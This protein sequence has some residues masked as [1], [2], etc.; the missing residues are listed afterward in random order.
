MITQTCDTVPQTELALNSVCHNNNNNNA[1]CTTHSTAN[2]THYS[3]VW[4]HV[5]NS[6][7]VVQSVQLPATGWTVLWSNSGGDEISFS[8]HTNTGIYPTSSRVDKGALT[9]GVKQPGCGI[10]DSIPYRDGV[11]HQYSCTSEQ[12]LYQLWL[13]MG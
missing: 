5:Y 13:V 11:K 12:L 2:C 9:S 6:A 8:F 4:L 1:L 3:N 7:K 10:D